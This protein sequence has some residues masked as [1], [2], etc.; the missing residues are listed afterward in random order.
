M[1]C[2]NCG[3]E[4]MSPVYSTSRYPI[5]RCDECNHE[6]IGGTVSH[7]RWCCDMIFRKGGGA[8][9]STKESRA[10]WAEAL[11]AREAAETAPPAGE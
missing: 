3:S 2:Q 6:H 11:L 8:R 9:G 1:K 7:D 4:S 5:T 10:R